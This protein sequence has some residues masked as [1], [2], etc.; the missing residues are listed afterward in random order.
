VKAREEVA[1]TVSSIL[2]D[3]ALR[4]KSRRTPSWV[5]G[6]VAFVAMAVVVLLFPPPGMESLWLRI[7]FLIVSAMLATSIG[8]GVNWALCTPF[9]RQTRQRYIEAFPE[10]EERRLADAVLAEVVAHDRL[11]HMLPRLRSRLGVIV[12]EFKCSVCGARVRVQCVGQSLKCRRC[13]AL[14][15][16]PSAPR[17]PGCGNYGTTLLSPDQQVSPS[18]KQDTGKAAGAFRSRRIPRRRTDGR[19]KGR[20]QR[21]GS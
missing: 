14:L 13:G 4:E 10:P 5:A 19:R 11:I 7:L 9:E 1:Q 15:H 3:L 21:R 6:I 16:V 17:C 2:N 20:W 8:Y 12:D 18:K